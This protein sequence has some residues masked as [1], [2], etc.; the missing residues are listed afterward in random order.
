V[1]QHSYSYISYID[2]AASE[3]QPIPSAVQTF[4]AA[5]IIKHRQRRYQL[6]LVKTTHFTTHLAF[7]RPTCD[8]VLDMLN[9]AEIKSGVSQLTPIGQPHSAPII[10]ARCLMLVSQAS[11]LR[12]AATAE[13]M[14]DKRRKISKMRD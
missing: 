10:S 2:I 12:P 11:T 4:V 8:I 6:F 9:G 13:A 14:L 7:N 3:G 5:P 1:L